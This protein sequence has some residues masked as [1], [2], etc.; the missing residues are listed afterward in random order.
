MRVK[1]YSIDNEYVI[2]WQSELGVGVNGKVISCVNKK[3]KQNYALKII[4]DC[5]KARREIELHLLASQHPNIVKIY[6]VFSNKINDIEYLLVV[7]E[8]MM[9]GELFV[10]IQKKNCSGFTEKEASQVICKICHIISYLHDLNIAHRDIK[11]E[12]LLFTDENENAELKLTDFGFAKYSP[13]EDDNFTET[14]CYTPLYVAPEVLSS[15]KYCKSRDVWS[16]G[17]ITY[18]LLCGYPPFYSNNGQPISPGMKARIKKGQYDFPAPEW[19]TVSAVA[20]DFVKKLLEVDPANRLTIKEALKHKWITHFNKTPMVFEI[21]KN[22]ENKIEWHKPTD[23]SDDDETLQNRSSKK[24]LQLK[25]LPESNNQLF[26]K[27]REK[28]E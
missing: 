24:E 1:N 16:V 8:F 13:S 15:S 20:K 25:S 21:D 4:K 7:M 23:Q 11:P 10:K 2:D 22:H 14:P 12:N 5:P 27:R 26:L 9:G 18:I 19:D 3:S 6:D 28:K 17:I